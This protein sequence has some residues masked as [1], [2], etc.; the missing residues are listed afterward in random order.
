L[1]GSRHVPDSYQPPPGHPEPTR[2]ITVRLPRSL[3]ESLREE[4]HAH[5]TSM[6]QLCVAK[7]NRPIDDEPAD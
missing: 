5:Q 4:A 3:H 6:N 7:L 2:T 1:V